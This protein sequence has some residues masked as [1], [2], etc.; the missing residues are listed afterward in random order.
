MPVIL[1]VLV[2]RWRTLCC[3]CVCS[4]IRRFWAFHP[5][6]NGAFCPW[7]GLGEWREVALCSDGMPACPR[8]MLETIWFLK[9]GAARELYLGTV[10]S[11]NF[12]GV[13]S[14]TL[15]LNPSSHCRGFQCRC[16]DLWSLSG[17]PCS[18]DGLRGL[19]RPL[20]VPRP[21]R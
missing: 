7:R 15:E 5:Q 11:R 17:A 20:L 16:A 6:N 14:Y 10:L 4:N 3:G 12:V 1:Q 18:P 9:S 2:T 19:R 13:C 8:Y 21:L